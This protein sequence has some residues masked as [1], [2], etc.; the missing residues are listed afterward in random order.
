M[1][2][3]GL[4][5]RM[6]YACTLCSTESKVQW[7]RP[8][9][10][11]W[12]EHKEYIDLKE[13]NSERPQYFWC[14]YHQRAHDFTR[15][16]LRY[17]A[18]ITVNGEKG[19]SG[20]KRSQLSHEDALTQ[21]REYVAANTKV[22]DWKTIIGSNSLP[23]PCTRASRLLLPDIIYCEPDKQARYHVSITNIIEFE[24]K[25]TA[26][27]IVDKVQR[28]NVSSKRMIE[29]NAQNKKK[30]PRI[31]FLY[32]RNTTISLDHIKESISRLNYEYLDS[33][34]VNYYDEKGKWF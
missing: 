4:H 11:M 8:G 2:E 6:Y 32:D 23:W 20:I 24:T 33:V 21:I 17:R 29:G 3:L 18:I 15:E 22:L 26:E 28:Y 7:H 16:C 5:G 34:I 12:R 1:K 25:T 19:N 14:T 10:K 31:I 13:T 9:T 27:V 30:L